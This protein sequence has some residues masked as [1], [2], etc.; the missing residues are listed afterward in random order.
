ML[1]STDG[2]TPGDASLELLR[3]R[4]ALRTGELDGAAAAF[5][6]GEALGLPRSAVLPHLAEVAYRARRFPA[7]RACLGPVAHASAA[8]VRRVAS[9]WK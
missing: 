3:G 7:V 6:R 5:T 2:T 4:I 1:A 9:F 8:T